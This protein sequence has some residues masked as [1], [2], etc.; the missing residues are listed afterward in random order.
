MK[1]LE[2]LNWNENQVD[3]LKFFGFSYLK[4]GKY[5]VALEVFLGL[6]VLV[7]HDS[8]VLKTLGALYLELK[9]PEKAL[10]ILEEASLLEPSNEFVAINRVQSLIDLGRTQEAMQSAKLLT[11]NKN[12]KVADRAKALIMAWS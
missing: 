3:D 12:K 6:K 5:D 2:M 9:Q 4:Q 1:W 7:P 8:Y 11:K 10:P